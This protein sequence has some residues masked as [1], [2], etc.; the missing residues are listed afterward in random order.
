[1]TEVSPVSV[2]IRDHARMTTSLE[3]VEEQIRSGEITKARQTLDAVE[4][5]EGASAEVFFLQGLAREREFDREGAVTLF[6]RAL[7][8][9]PGHQ[10]AAFHAATICDQNGDE[11]AAL[12]LYEQCV[13]HPPIPVNALI[14]LAV[15]Y[16][17]DGRFDDAERLLTAVLDEHPNHFRATQFLKSVKSSY[18]MMYD[19]Q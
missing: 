7:E 16:E 11:E 15:L 2:L 6:L 8:Q 17:E 19:E 13:Q 4:Q 10:R 18:D 9:D 3:T 5:A 12:D 14:N 1:M